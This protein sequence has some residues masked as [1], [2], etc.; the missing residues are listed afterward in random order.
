MKDGRIYRYNIQFPRKTDLE[1]RAGE[2]LETLGRRKSAVIIAALNEY[3]DHHPE[4]LDGSHSKICVSSL[5]LQDLE[6][7]IQAMIEERL[8]SIDR[9]PSPT[10]AEHPESLSISDHQETGSVC[11]D[12]M[13]MLDDLELFTF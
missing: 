10:K 13:D 12:V 1:V 3:L 2:F 4:L 5:S 11:Q 9:T 7:K 8:K 6:G